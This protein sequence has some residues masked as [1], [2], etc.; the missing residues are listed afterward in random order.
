MGEDKEYILDYEMS[1]GMERKT[2]TNLLEMWDYVN[3]L[4]NDERTERIWLYTR[5][6]VW[7]RG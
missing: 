2:F 3:K 1:Y 4:R 6:T 7:K 5:Q